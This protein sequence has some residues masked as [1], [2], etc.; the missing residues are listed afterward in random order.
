MAALATAGKAALSDSSPSVIKKAGARAPAFFRLERYLK[1]IIASGS[2][3]LT[4][5]VSKMRR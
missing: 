4:R 2:F 5:A 3:T 1:T